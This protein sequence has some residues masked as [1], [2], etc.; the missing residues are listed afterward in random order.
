MG[1]F[2]SSSRRRAPRPRTWKRSDR[3]TPRHSA[4]KSE[5]LGFPG[6]W[7]AEDRDLL[8]RVV[9]DSI[10]PLMT[11]RAT[12]PRG[13]WRRRSSSRRS[14]SLR[15]SPGSTWSARRLSRRWGCRRSHSSW[16]AAAMLAD[17]VEQRERAARRRR[18]PGRGRRRTP[19]RCRPRRGGRRRRISAPLIS[20]GVGG[21]A[22]RFS[23]GSMPTSF[24]MARCTSRASSSMSTW[25]S[26]QTKRPS[27]SRA[28]GLISASV[29]PYAWKIRASAATNLRQAVEVR[30]R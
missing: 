27:A 5:A 15:V 20:N 19:P 14:S 1:T 2:I 29:R 7:D 3:S 12:Y 17:G 6:P 24:K 22:W 23:A 26:R 8:G 30:T 13:C 10:T 25:P 18:S 9:P 21:R 4:A 28:S 11:P 16:R